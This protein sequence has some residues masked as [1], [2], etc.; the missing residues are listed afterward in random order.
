[1]TVEF[2]GSV[3]SDGTKTGH[4]A[5]PVIL[6]LRIVMFRLTG[7]DGCAAGARVGA[8][9][10]AAEVVEAAA[11]DALAGAADAATVAPDALF[12]AD[13]GKV[14]PGAAEAPEQAPAASATAPAR[15]VRVRERRGGRIGNAP[16]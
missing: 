14:Q 11:G 16:A 5:F 12:A 9:V 4:P 8:T 7:A 13:G 3:K 10:G 15:K 1:M 6:S 2:A